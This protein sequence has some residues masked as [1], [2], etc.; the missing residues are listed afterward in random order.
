MASVYMKDYSPDYPRKWER[1]WYDES[2]EVLDIRRRNLLDVNAVL[3]NYSVTMIPF[4]G[5]L[6]GMI[7]ENDLIRG[8]RDDDCI[9]MH[10]DME[11]FSEEVLAQL[12][13]RGFELCRIYGEGEGHKHCIT[14]GRH[15]RTVDLTLYTPHGGE[16]YKYHN[17]THVIHRS[18]LDNLQEI[19]MWSDTF[20]IP[21][22]NEKV[23]SAIYGQDWRTPKSRK[24]SEGYSLMEY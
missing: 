19:Q 8:D 21:S 5:T 9:I 15:D 23:L 17:S 6:L 13:L 2:D 11:K 16:H 4:Y 1:L 20:K 10:T 12:Q 14:L 7:R 18:Y 22:K 24:W 3:K